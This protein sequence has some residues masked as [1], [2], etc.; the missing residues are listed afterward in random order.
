VAFEQVPAP[1]TAVGFANDRVRVYLRLAVLESDIAGERQ[2]VDLLLERDALVV[3]PLAL[4][5]AKC[6]VAEC[7][8]RPE[9]RGS[10]LL[11]A[12]ELQQEPTTSS[13][14]SKINK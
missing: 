5:E 13:P 3:L 9:A 14:S 10:Q 4:K 8:D 1:R 6:D 12:G 7:P 2:H 11:L